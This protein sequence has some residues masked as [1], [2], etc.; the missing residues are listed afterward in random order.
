M[1]QP[2]IDYWKQLAAV[3]RDKC[4]NLYVQ[5]SNGGGCNPITITQV[6]ITNY[7]LMLSNAM[8]RNRKTLHR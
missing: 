8:T 3:L 1:F 2:P 5:D 4:P 7:L 6:M